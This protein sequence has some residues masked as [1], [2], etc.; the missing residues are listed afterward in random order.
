MVFIETLEQ[1]VAR[2][3]A[4]GRRRKR[5][6]EAQLHW[7]E[8]ELAAIEGRSVLV[9][10]EAARRVA[11]APQDG[12]HARDEL[13]DA[14]R[15]ADV[16]IRAEIQADQAIDLLHLGGHHHDGNVGEGA[17]LAAHLQAVAAGQH[18][19]E[20]DQVRR[21]RPYPAHHL[22]TVGDAMRLVALRLQVVRLERGELRLVFHDEDPA[23]AALRSDAGRTTRTRRP[24]SGERSARMSPPC[25]SAMLRHKARPRPA[26]PFARLR[27]ASTRKK[28]SKSR[29]SASGGTPG[30][31]SSKSIATRSWSRRTAT[32]TRPP[33]SV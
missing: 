21:I 20:Q 7:R 25:A 30:A 11:R 19:I 16:V 14:E 27:D 29:G 1:P 24:P 4:A 33:I 2:E 5:A 31:E 18:E 17:Q 3:H 32:R 15:F 23:H 26:P 9:D 28:R 8:V 22:G 13:A 6:Q 12:A 10:R